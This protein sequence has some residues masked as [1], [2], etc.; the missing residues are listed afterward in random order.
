MIQLS[1]II[2][3]YKVPFYLMQC[4]SSVEKA[5]QGISSEIIVVDNHSQDQS[6]D[7]VKQYFPNVRLLQQQRE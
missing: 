4:L 3:N 6:C 1:V 2:L 7:W 5:L